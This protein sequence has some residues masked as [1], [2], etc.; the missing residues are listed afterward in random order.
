MLSHISILSSFNGQIIFHF[1]DIPHLFIHLSGDEHFSCFYFLNN[2][3]M[4][5]KLHVTIFVYHRYLSRN[6]T[7][8]SHRNFMASFSDKLLKSFPN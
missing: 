4:K 5:I 8:A 6:G 2:I 1:M 7:V 3:A